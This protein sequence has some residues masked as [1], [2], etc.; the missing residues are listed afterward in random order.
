VTGA[1]WLTWLSPLGWMTKIQPYGANRFAVALLP[2]AVFGVLMVVA[3]ALLERRDLGAGLVPARPGPQHGGRWLASSLGLA[4]RLQYWS[5]L[6]W[7]LAIALGG[8]LIGSLAGSLES[9]LSDSAMQDMLRSLG[10]NGPTSL[11]DLFL[12]AEFSVLGLVVAGYGIAATLRLRGEERDTHAEAVLATPTSR[13][14]FLAGHLLIALLGS[15]WLLL[16]LGVVVGLIR[17]L[18]TGDVAGQ[19]STLVPAALGP[20]PAVWVCVGLTVLIFGL[21]PQ[22]TS[23]AWILLILFLVVGELGALLGL[24]AWL[25][26]VSPFAHLPSLPGG[27]VTVGPLMVLAVAALALLSSGSVGFRRRDVG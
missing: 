26:D 9:M 11:A 5:L 21:V 22:W 23:G 7:T 19:L 13:W 27:A 17:G 3:L 2:L 25:R 14:S 8:G 15:T 4:W 16:V 20:L 1:G 6:G 18:A 12:A 10:G 24:P